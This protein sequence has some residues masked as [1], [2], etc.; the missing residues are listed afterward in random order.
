MRLL[1]LLQALLFGLASGL[2]AAQDL[3]SPFCV[4]PVQGGTPTEKDFNDAWRMVSKVVTLAGLPRPIIYAYNRGGVWTIDEN[5][6]FVPFGGEFPS[7]PI[8]D[9]IARDP[10]SGRFVGINNALGIFVLD[11]GQSQF[12]KLYSVGDASLRHPYSVEFIPRF[13]GFVISDASGLY[14]LDRTGGLSPLP[15]ADHATL[16][17]PFRVFDLPTFNALVV[18]AQDSSAVV[19]Y[20]DGEIVRVTTLDRGDYVLGVTV[21]TDGRVL[22]RGNKKTRTFSLSRA[23]AEPIVQG[24][25][26]VIGD[27]PLRVSRARLDAPSIDKTIA[28]N[29]RSGLAELGPSGPIPIT[30]P[31]DPAEEPIDSIM[32]LPEYR[33]VFIITRASAYAL[34]DKGSV[35]EIPGARVAGASRLGALVRLI[36]VRNETIYLGWNSLNLLLDRRISGDTACSE[37]R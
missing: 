14:L 18:N 36:P 11:P 20:D 35:T 10:D 25:S 7:N 6:A 21:E 15:I 9:Q 34:Q 23:P 3:S 27:V 13:A 32:E 1:A 33:A 4:I 29:P 30:L 31:F 28:M 37:R 5:R 22:L 16:R 17:I 24:R 19:R 2:A 12:R 26:F 8:H